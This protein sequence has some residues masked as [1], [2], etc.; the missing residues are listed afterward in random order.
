MKKILRITLSLL[1]LSTTAGHAAQPSSDAAKLMKQLAALTVDRNQIEEKISDKVAVLK[2]NTAKAD[3]LVSEAKEIA[4]EDAALDAERAS[5]NQL[6]HRTVPE[7]QLAAAKAACEAWLNPFNARVDTV[8]AKKEESSRKISALESD[9]ESGMAEFERLSARD[10]ELTKQ[11]TAVQK[12]ILLA[13]HDTC[14]QSCLDAEKGDTVAQCMQNC[15]D[16][17]R[18]AGTL[19]VL[20]DPP[21]EKPSTRTPQQAIDEYQKRPNPGPNSLHTKEVPPP[22]V[23]P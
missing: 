2:S 12:T 23:T 22:A 20:P 9:E 3:E 1:L 19:P 5:H 11:I 17:A 16:G 4:S 14:S 10:D 7:D 15:W 6:C 13:K 8:N 21:M 18:A